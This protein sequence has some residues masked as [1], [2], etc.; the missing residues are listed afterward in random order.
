MPSMDLFDKQDE[1]YKEAVLPKDVRKRVAIEMGASFGWERY[2]GLDG[3]TV[4]IDHFGASAPG[5]KLIEE[6]GFT[7]EEVVKKYSQL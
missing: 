5:G 1:A 7:I 6:F 2:V 4:T 3:T